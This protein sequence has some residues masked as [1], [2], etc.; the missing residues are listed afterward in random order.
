M[1]HLEGQ[2]LSR[3]RSRVGRRDM[4]IP[5]AISM[6]ILR[7]TLAGLSYAHGLIDHDG[8]PL[9]VVHRDVSPE[10]IMVTYAGQTKLVDF[11]VAKT[12]ASMSRTRAGVLKGKVAYMA[13]EQARSDTTIDERADVFAAGLLLWEMLTNK[14]LWEGLSEEEVFERLL[15]EA[16]LPRVRTVDPEIPEELDELC[17]KAMQKD[18][19]RRFAS[20][21][22]LLDALEK[23]SAEYDLRAS[24]REVGQFVIERFEAER[25]KVRTL[26]SNAVAK[27]KEAAAAAAAAETFFLPRPNASL[28][29]AQQVAKAEPAKVE[30]AP[31]AQTEAAEPEPA[32]PAEPPPSAKLDVLT[33]TP[34]EAAAPA[35]EKSES[36]LVPPDQHRLSPE[37]RGQRPGPERVVAV[38]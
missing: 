16:P 26:V 4:T 8:T 2:P 34:L 24:K 13:P 1:E 31:P 20:A 37:R 3:I 17:A 14:R 28:E 29:P 27:S 15:D 21:S 7:D 33:S 11:G 18:K 22:D 36:V 12:V 32:A 38:G 23:A 19:E 10:N 5:R 9:R 30:P 35:R 25:D 6:E